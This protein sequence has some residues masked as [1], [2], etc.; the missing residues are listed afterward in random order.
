MM[1]LFRVFAAD[2]IS[3]EGRREDNPKSISEDFP[4]SGEVVE[5]RNHQEYGRGVGSMEQSL[6]LVASWL[7]ANN[8]I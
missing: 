1:S 5:Q 7:P 4:S 2:L 3:E 8:Q 6:K